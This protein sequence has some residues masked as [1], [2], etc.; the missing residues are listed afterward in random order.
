MLSTFKKIGLAV[1]ITVISG[2]S[3]NAQA[4]QKKAKVIKHHC[5]AACVNGKHL[6]AHGEKGHVCTAECKKM[7]EEKLALKEHVCIAACIDGK[8][9]YAH[10]EKGHVCTEACKTKM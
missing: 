10:G 2:A 4:T 1:L 5:T 6:Y 9:M 7:A 3:V 8:H